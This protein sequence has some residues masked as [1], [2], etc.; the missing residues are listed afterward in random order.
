MLRVLVVEDERKVRDSLVSGIRDAGFEV[1]DAEDGRAALSRLSE[2]SYAVVV[3]DVMLPDMTGYD[4]LSTIREHYS[5]TR[6]LLLTAIDRVDDKITALNAGADD[7]LTKPFV[8]EELVARL[9]ALSRRGKLEEGQ[10][11]SARTLVMDRVKKTVT[12]DGMQLHLTLREYSL[13]EFLMLHKNEIV[14]RNMISQQVWKYGFEA[15][16]NVID[17]YINYLRRKIDPE[18]G[19]S[20]ITTIRGR[21]FMISDPA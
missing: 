6:V 4:I 18:D 9:R 10:R 1:H 7:Y 2:A 20:F 15:E 16:S 11:L 19:P 12:R 21:G 3:L 14:S 5:D 8:F 17:V 13:L